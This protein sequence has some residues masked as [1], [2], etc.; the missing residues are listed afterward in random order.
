VGE[1]GRGL[2]STQQTT[3]CGQTPIHHPAVTVH[4][5]LV[6][7]CDGQRS[8]NNVTL[9]RR[10]GSVLDYSRHRAPCSVRDG[11]RGQM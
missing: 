7:T 3:G 9:Y 8:Y 6:L 11:H 1:V 5:W 4:L 10:N 2:A